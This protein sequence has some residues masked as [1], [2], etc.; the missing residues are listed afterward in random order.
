M[1]Q[2]H[3]PLPN[4][5]ST[6]SGSVWC[7]WVLRHLSSYQRLVGFANFPSLDPSS[8]KITILDEAFWG[9]ITNEVISQNSTMPLLLFKS[10]TTSILLRRNSISSSVW[11]VSPLLPNRRDPNSQASLRPN[12][13]KLFRFTWN[14][15]VSVW[16]RKKSYLILSLNDKAFK[17]ELLP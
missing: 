9:N 11:D 13:K 2:H 14:N 17:T 8:L 6:M 12:S 1:Q 10:P 7:H 4:L 15:D 5:I 3:E 16:Q